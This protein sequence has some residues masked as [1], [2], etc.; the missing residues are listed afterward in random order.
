METELLFQEIALD[1]VAKGRVPDL[2]EAAALPFAAT[3]PAGVRW[4]T[5]VGRLKISGNSDVSYDSGMIVGICHY[6]ALWEYI[7]ICVYVITY[8]EESAGNGNI[9]ESDQ[10][11]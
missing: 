9:C 8:S 5:T 2:A 4:R 11:L 6:H 7:H 10:S 3:T 1:V